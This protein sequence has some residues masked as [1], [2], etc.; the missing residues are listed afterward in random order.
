MRK[1]DDSDFERGWPLFWCCY[2]GPL[3]PAWLLE[4]QRDAHLVR[5]HPGMPPIYGD[6]LY[7]I[8]RPI[9]MADIHAAYPERA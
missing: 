1:P 6:G 7:P 8:N 3:Q 2:C 4:V 9:T 5:H